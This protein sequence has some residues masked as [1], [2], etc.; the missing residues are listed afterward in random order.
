MIREAVTRLRSDV[1][2]LTF[3]EGT[4]YHRGEVLR[5]GAAS[6]A[7]PA[8]RGCRWCRWRCATRTPSSPGWARRLLA[9]HLRTA[10]K[11]V[12][13][14]HLHFLPALEVSAGGE[15]RCAK[16]ARDQV[17]ALAHLVWVTHHTAV[18][19]ER[20]GHVVLVAV[21]QRA[22]AQAEAEGHRPSGHGHTAH[23]DDQRRVCATARSLLGQAVVLLGEA[24]LFFGGAALGVHALGLESSRFF[25]GLAR[26]DAR[27]ELGHAGLDLGAVGRLGVLTQ[28]LL[29][30]REGLVVAAQTVERGADVV[31]QRRT[32]TEVVRL[33]EAAQRPLV[34]AHRERFAR[35]LE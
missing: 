20:G 14:V 3:A 28:E 19:F 33:L 6:S 31:E 34:L 25:T 4:N 21:I 35:G 13:H 24:T 27:A 26:L 1:S 10:S 8:S 32:A 9:A 17:R 18:L 11:P 23:G 7:R 16:H 22:R 30:D 12:T 5:S 15:D 2:V 29:E